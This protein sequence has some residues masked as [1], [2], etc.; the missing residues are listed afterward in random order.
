MDP[1]GQ[2]PRVYG[3]SVRSGMDADNTSDYGPSSGSSG[4]TSIETA[5]RYH[6]YE[7][8]R[9]APQPHTLTTLPRRARNTALTPSRRYQSFVEGRYPLPNDEGEQSR[10]MMLHTMVKE[11]LDG[12]LCLAPI[13]DYPQ[14]ILDLGTGCGMWAVD[15]EPPFP[16]PFPSSTHRRP[17][18]DDDR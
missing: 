15:G 14:K 3:T 13:G 7:N 12:K 18:K 4:F 2:R 8:G 11:L 16:S 10:E 5:A 17:R 6:V 9:Y 1:N